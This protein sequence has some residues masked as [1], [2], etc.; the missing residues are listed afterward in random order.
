MKNK[1][2][3]INPQPQHLPP[4]DKHRVLDSNGNV[5][6]LAPFEHEGDMWRVTGS[7]FEKDVQRHQVKNTRTGELIFVT[8][9]SFRKKFIFAE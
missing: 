3:H 9:E 2:T 1:N 5:R 6:T 7:N 4:V 8:L